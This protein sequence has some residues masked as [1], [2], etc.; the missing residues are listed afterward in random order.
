MEEDWYWIKEL[1]LHATASPKQ[2]DNDDDD[3]K[4]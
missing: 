2:Y 4:N 3:K 1:L